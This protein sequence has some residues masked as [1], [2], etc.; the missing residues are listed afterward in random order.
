[1]PKGRRHR[2]G[3]AGA[4]A[5]RG[6]LRICWCRRKSFGSRE[7]RAATEGTL[8]RPKERSATEAS[9]R[10][11]WSDRKR[12]ERGPCIGLAASLIGSRRKQPRLA[13]DGQLLGSASSHT[14]QTRQPH[15][16]ACL[17]RQEPG[18][19]LARRGEEGAQ[20]K[21]GTPAERASL[22]QAMEGELGRPGSDPGED[23]A[24]P[25]WGASAQPARFNR[26][27]RRPA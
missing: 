8:Y 7:R 21:A 16:P 14:T 24:Q 2:P 3:C 9:I 26:R 25:G 13:I 1:M 6:Q 27:R 5:A 12:A 17:A 15:G 23:N 20:P 19:A 11:V 18:W 10:S 4:D 22:G